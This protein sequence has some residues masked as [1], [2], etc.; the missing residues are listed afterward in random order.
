MR[1][2]CMMY[3]CSNKIGG[4]MM[5]LKWKS[6]FVRKTIASVLAI[7]YLCHNGTNAFIC[8]RGIQCKQG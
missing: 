6:S 2:F 4:R 7:K 3:T 1:V 8:K 5:K